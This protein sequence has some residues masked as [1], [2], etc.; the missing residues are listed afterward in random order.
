[1]ARAYYVECPRC[2]D[3]TVALFNEFFPAVND[4]CVAMCDSCKL[5]FSLLSTDYCKT[6]PEFPSCVSFP[7]IDLLGI[8]IKHHQISIEPRTGMRVILCKY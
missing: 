4:Q 1:M 6:C 5:P 8:L 7:S 3:S 2:K